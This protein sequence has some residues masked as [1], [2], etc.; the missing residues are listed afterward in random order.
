MFLAFGSIL[1][2]VVYIPSDFS[3]EYEPNKA[4]LRKKVSTEL[5]KGDVV[6]FHSLLLHRANKNNTDKAKLSFVY[7]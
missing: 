4:I 6:I 3:Q 7:T 5:Q 2:S 1:G